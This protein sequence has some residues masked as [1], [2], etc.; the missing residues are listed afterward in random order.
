MRTCH[1]PSR[2]DW[3]CLRAVR[4]CTLDV[5]ECSTLAHVRLQR[6]ISAG[7]AGGGRVMHDFYL[8][9]RLLWIRTYRLAGLMGSNSW[10]WSTRPPRREYI[11]YGSW[12]S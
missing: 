7:S 11:N 12:D 9:N 10:W 6:F 3:W 1:V 2:C 4:S 5:S 8:G